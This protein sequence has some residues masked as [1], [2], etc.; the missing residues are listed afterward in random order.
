MY[1]G[2]LVQMITTKRPTDDMIEVAIVVDG[3]GARRRRRT[4]SRTGSTP[5]EREPM[6]FGTRRRRGAA[7]RGGRE[8]RRHDEHRRATDRRGH[9][10]PRRQARGGRAPSTTTSRPSWHARR[11]CADPNEI[12]RLGPGARPPRA[13]RRGVPAA[14]ATRAELAGAREL[15]DARRRRRRAAGDGPRRDRPARGR[16]DAPAR[17]AQGPAAAARPER[18]PRRHPRDPRRGRRR[19]GGAVRRRAAAGCTCATRT[20]TASRPRS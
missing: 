4:R 15:R 13:R 17:G 16:R 2:I 8:R 19:G 3:G 7:R 1:P 20:A 14:E 5:F 12:R 18:R 10:R 11:S 9:E 6:D